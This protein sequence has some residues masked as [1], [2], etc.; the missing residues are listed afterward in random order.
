MAQKVSSEESKSSGVGS[1]FRRWGMPIGAV[2]V[3]AVTGMVASS[4][5]GSHDADLAK[6][7]NEITSLKSQIDVTNLDRQAKVNKVKSQVVG[8]SSERQS[9]DNKAIEGLMSKATTWSSYTEYMAARDDIKKTYKLDEKSSF[10]STFM[11][12]IGNLQD[13]MGTN[14]NKIDTEHLNAKMTGFSSSIVK[15][16]GLSYSYIGLA[17]IETTSANKGKATTYSL[18]EYTTDA[19]HKLSKISAYPVLTDPTILGSMRGTTGV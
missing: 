18:V 2:G 3:L 13:G 4:I 1:F 14:Y 7:Q 15:V 17:S 19:Q 5:N 10:L 12:K 6:Q 8:L 9:G 11:P 16:A